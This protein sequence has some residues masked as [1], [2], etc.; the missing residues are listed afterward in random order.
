M[1]SHYQQM[2]V[3]EG[4]LHNPHNRPSGNFWTEVRVKNC[5]THEGNQSQI[6]ERILNSGLNIGL[7]DRL[8]LPNTL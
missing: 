6:L 8:A 3:L 7:N 2:P 1:V 4:H 5:K